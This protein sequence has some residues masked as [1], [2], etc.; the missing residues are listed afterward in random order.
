M[1][2]V[3]LGEDVSRDSLLS[4]I[5]NIWVVRT[6][7]QFSMVSVDTGPLSLEERVEDLVETLENNNLQEDSKGI[8]EAC[9]ACGDRVNNSETNEQ[10]NSDILGKF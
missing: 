3:T 8:I 9:K 1:G 7:S 10:E 4:W 6:L 2:R 5:L